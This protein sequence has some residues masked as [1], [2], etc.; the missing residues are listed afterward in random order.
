M[1]TGF[2]FRSTYF[3]TSV[4]KDHFVNPSCYGDDLA[5]WLIAR[6]KA[7]GIE[8]SAEP[9]PEDFGWYFTFVLDRTKYCVVLGFQPNDPDSGDCWIGW[10]ERDAGFLGSIM[11]RRNRGISGDA[12]AILD[13]VL[14]S[15]PEIRDLVWLPRGSL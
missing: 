9:R 10:I 15:S 14:R 6:F 3:N 7:S 2:Q 4:P 11:G 8:T 13:R 5:E 12:I 1:E